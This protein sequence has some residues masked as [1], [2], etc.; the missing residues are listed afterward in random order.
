MPRAMTCQPTQQ[1]SQLPCEQYSRDLAHLRLSER[2]SDRVDVC[3]GQAGGCQQLQRHIKPTQQVRWSGRVSF[4]C[5][6]ADIQGASGR[7]C[8]H[9][10][11]QRGSPQPRPGAVR[12]QNSLRTCHRGS[13][14]HLST[15]C[16]RL[17]AC[18]IVYFGSSPISGFPM[19]VAS[20]FHCS[21]FMALTTISPSAKSNA[22]YGTMLAWAVPQRFVGCPEFNTLLPTLTKDATWETASREVIAH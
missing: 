9:E 20:F 7:G 6:G 4:T 19:H 5:M 18:P 1:S 16:S 11:W 21:S 12:V 17:Q 2:L 10:M 14:R 8:Q 15:S 3:D 22:W 13:T